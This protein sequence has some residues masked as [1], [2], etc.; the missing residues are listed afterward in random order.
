MSRAIF[1]KEY[2]DPGRCAAARAHHAWLAAL[3]S[4]VRLPRLLDADD[5]SLVYEFLPGRAGR[6]EDLPRLAA[7]VGRL[8]AA[9]HRH[10]VHDPHRRET[11]PATAG[12]SI[13]DFATPR[14]QALEREAA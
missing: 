11:Y 7:T 6:P 4:Q 3:G 10:I 5:H 9:A 13:P 12:P 14:R 2:D 8:D 1:V